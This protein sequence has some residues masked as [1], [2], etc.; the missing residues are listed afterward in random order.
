MHCFS[1]HI[2]NWVES[3]ALASF[4]S[5][6]RGGFN[7]GKK[8]ASKNEGLHTLNQALVKK[9]YSALT[10]ATPDLS[11]PANLYLLK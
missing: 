7:K 1:S 6:I 5:K 2:Q 10:Y 3:S 11:D 4:Y 9:F 8:A